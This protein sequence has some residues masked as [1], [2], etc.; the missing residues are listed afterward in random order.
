MNF[1]DKNGYGEL[2]NIYGHKMLYIWE[3]YCGNGIIRHLH[4]DNDYEIFLNT[5]FITEG[6]RLL[7]GVR[8]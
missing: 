4:Y 5:V 3:R 2:K 8:I 1:L 6:L 7:C